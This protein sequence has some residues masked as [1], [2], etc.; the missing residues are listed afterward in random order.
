MKGNDSKKA[1][2]DIEE[3]IAGFPIEVQGILK[4][5]RKTIQQAAPEATESISYGIPTF[6]QHGALVHFGGYKQHIGFY[7]A[8]RAIEVFKEELAGYEGGKG[9]VKFPI[10]RP[11]PMDLI[12]RIV[13]YR[14][15]ENLARLKK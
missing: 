14:L 8:P 11:I 15:K 6:S 1:P 3:Y 13:Q 12:R 7:P 5:I 4:A 9:T 10:D 2:Q